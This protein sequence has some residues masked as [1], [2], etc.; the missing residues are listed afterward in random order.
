MLSRLISVLL[1]GAAAMLTVACGSDSAG[2][3]QPSSSAD[4]RPLIVRASDTFTADSFINA[5]WKKNKQLDES[6]LDG[7]TSAWYGF[8]DQ[9]D[10][11]LWLYETNEDAA[12]IG[13]QTAQAAIDR[14]GG[15]IKEFASVAVHNFGY[16]DYL[17]V[18]NVVM[19]CEREVAACEALVA[20][21]D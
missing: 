10:I 9:R 11:E 2:T 5:G 17:V 21:L 3:D 20:E 15:V 18:G 4:S 7:T 14:Q 8:F 6:L 12:S 16:A 13:A 19:M 1:I